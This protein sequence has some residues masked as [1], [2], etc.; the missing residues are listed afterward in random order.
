MAGVRQFNED[1]AFEKALALFWKKGFAETSMQELAAVTGVQRGS[2]YNAYQSKETLFLH[3]F[4]RYSEHIFAQVSAALDKPTLRGALRAFFAFMIGS[5]TTGMPARGCLST[6]AAFGRDV[7]D[8]PIR[9]ALQRMLDGLEAVLA[10]RLARPEK[11]VRL[12]VSPQ[13]A[14][15][16]IVTLT[17]GIVVIERIYQDKRRL[18]A[19]AE[20]LTAL[21]LGAS[22]R[23]RQTAAA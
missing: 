16:L 6:K 13:E 20:A 14:A 10:E 4:V 18:R 9:E 19:D 7:I 22:A 3:V 8:E 5:M 15:R 1:E 11:G 2:L 21:I 17:R 23:A 12:G